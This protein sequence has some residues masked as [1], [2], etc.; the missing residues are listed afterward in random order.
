MLKT[1]QTM[2]LALVMLLGVGVTASGAFAADKVTLKDGTVLEGKIVREANGIVWIKVNVSGVE[3]ERMLLPSEVKTVERD[4][5][6]KSADKADSK[7]ETKADSKTDSDAITTPVIVPGAGNTNV[8]RA[9]VLTMGD[10]TNGNDMVGVYM[11]AFS[12]QESLDTIKKELGEDGTGVL[13][14]RINSGGGML[15]EIQKLSDMIQNEL[16]PKFRVVGWIEFATSAAAMTAHAIEEIYFTRRGEYGSCTGFRGNQFAPM[17]GYELEVV[18]HMMERISARGKHNPLIMRAMQIQQPLSATVK[19]DGT[20]EWYPDAKGGEI[21]VNRDGEVLS[22]NSLEAERVK[23]SRGT[24]D[25]LEE[26][27]KAMGY[28]E[29]N[30][31]GERVEGVPW[32]VSKAEKAQMDFRSKTRDAENSLQV[33]NGKFMRLAQQAQQAQD[34]AERSGLVGS[35]RREL[36]KIEAHIRNNPRLTLINWGGDEQFREWIEERR[37]FLKNLLR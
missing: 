21:V 13:V 30:W 36:D 18:L 12:V 11:T 2:C 4:A 33:I 10:A 29:L 22:F 3:Q 24:A 16:K 31:V 17:E 9:M 15:L 20:V 1:L 5:G 26:L 32:P 7:S 27:T 35:A 19:P 25:T 37:E 14:L 23:F 28:N 8:P 6:G 34:R